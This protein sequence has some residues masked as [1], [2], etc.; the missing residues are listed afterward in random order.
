MIIRLR[1]LLKSK[2]FLAILFVKCIFLFVSVADIPREL[3]LPFFDRAVQHLG[4]NPWSIS[5]AGSFPYGSFLFGVLWLPKWVLYQIFGDVALGVG[6]VSLFA[7]KF[8][9]LVFDLLF[10]W[11]LSIFVPPRRTDLV[12]LYWANPILFYITYIHGQLDVVSM[13]LCSLS[14]LYMMRDRIKLSAVM[15]GLATASKFHVVA[16]VPFLLVYLWHKE[17]RVTAM[18]QVASWTSIWFGISVLGFGPLVASGVFGDASLQS[19]ELLRLFAAQLNVGS[20]HVFYIGIFGTLL[21]LGRLVISTY[22]SEVGLFLGTGVLFS[23]LA[24]FSNSAPGWYYWCVPFLAVFFSMYLNAPRVL[25]VA[26]TGGYLLHFALVDFE[27]GFGAFLGTS[28]PLLV[29]IAFT[30]MQTCLLACLGFIWTTALKSEVRIFHR[31]KPL[32]I[33]IAGDSGAGKNTLTA[34]LEMLFGRERMAIIE[35][36]NYHKWERGDDNWGKYTHLNP[37]ANH[38]FSM[39]KH[40]SA[41]TQG[42]PIHYAEYSHESG[43]F[44]PVQEMR[45]SRTLVVQGLHT[46][47]LRGMREEFDLKIYL[48]PD[49]LLRRA[50]KIRR[51][52]IDRG[53]NKEK[54]LS[55]MIERATDSEVYI[56]S[57][58]RFA[59]LVIEVKPSVAFSEGE[60]NEGVIPS[61]SV[62]FTTWN[63]LD[64]SAFI[65]EC[66]K[67]GLAVAVSIPRDNVDRVTLTFSQEPLES[68]LKRLASGLF[69]TPRRITRGVSAPQWRSGFAGVSQV[70]VLLALRARMELAP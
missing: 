12:L 68:Q 43:R 19:P 46:F 37:K 11:T 67:Q 48:N 50:W 35:G 44:K 63:D 7:L 17:F 54:V 33:G 8:P 40:T 25:L 28:K 39:F 64:L 49:P 62:S 52:C 15:F 56:Q 36:D 70:L 6:P 51:D 23:A 57:Q 16:V 55:Q 42:L 26:L 27:P 24:F 4:E 31:L 5:P 20:N 69:P 66:E 53:Y 41:L 3:F 9:L 13:A 10:F 14:L 59:D 22:I 58:K 1:E 18:R 45:P 32:R 21:V 38:V 47:F 65:G 61:T 2:L 29:S 30:F 34:S 60:A